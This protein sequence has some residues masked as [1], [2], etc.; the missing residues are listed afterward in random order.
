MALQVSPV[1]IPYFTNYDPNATMGCNGETISNPTVGSASLP[2]YN[3]CIP[4][5]IGCTDATM[6]NY[7]ALANFDDG[8][9]LP[10]VYGC[11][12]G[13]ATNYN[14]SANTPCNGTNDP[15]Q[16]CINDPS[17]TMQTGPN[18]CC[19]Q[20]IL[21]CMDDSVWDSNTLGNPVSWDGEYQYNYDPTANVNDISSCVY[22]YYGCMDALSCEY[23]SNGGPTII[24]TL[25]GPNVT[26]NA[27]DPNVGCCN[28]CGCTDCGTYWESIFTGQY[29]NGTSPALSVGSFNYNPAACFDNGSCVAV[30]LGCMDNTTPIGTG[31]NINGT[32]IG[33]CNYDPLA[34]VDDGSCTY[35][36]TTAGCLDPNALNFGDCGPCA[37]QAITGCADPSYGT[38]P[39][40]NGNCRGEDPL[41]I[42]SC[43]GNGCCGAGSSPGFQGTSQFGNCGDGSTC[44]PFGYTPGCCGTGNGI[45]NGWSALNY[46]ETCP[47]GSNVSMAPAPGQT[48]TSNCCDY[49]QSYN[50]TINN[51]SFTTSSVV[52]STNFFEPQNALISTSGS[53]ATNNYAL[54]SSILQGT[55]VTGEFNFKV[56]YNEPGPAYYVYYPPNGGAGC[57]PI[58]A[59]TT[60]GDAA[61]NLTACSIVL[62]GGNG[63]GYPGGGTGTSWPGANNPAEYNEIWS[64]NGTPT[65]AT[66]FE[67]N[68]QKLYLY[69]SI[70]TMF[71]T[72]IGSYITEVSS[73]E[74]YA[75]STAAVTQ[76]GLTSCDVHFPQAVWIK[77][78]FDF[79][80]PAN[81]V[82]IPLNVE[83]DVTRNGYDI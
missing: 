26:A 45:G 17:G 40:V 47:I 16:G 58:T 18:C 50:F 30:T 75:L 68:P 2:E 53:P 67:N 28:Y 63:I 14:A 11:T 55:Q 74:A 23:I 72:T 79:I 69:P 21:G 49:P 10:Y 7:N 56:Y 51:G 41:D 73:T 61:N 4:T 62:N 59:T 27:Q 33:A 80:M 19:Q 31:L 71:G 29:C 34:N 5:I 15:N 12:D 37:Y 43:V 76:A 24:T 42:Q 36:G 39:D 52:S 54:S 65:L 13:S 1:I 57:P 38:N 22:Q 82:N 77:V 6:F 60:S 35:G 66:Y 25:P 32:T 83:I 9:C 8:S 44:T 20:V 46:Y 78:T 81:D 64:N 3:C 70:N 48:I